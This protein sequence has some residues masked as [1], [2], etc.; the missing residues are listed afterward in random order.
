M[1]GRHQL[2]I[3][4]QPLA[5]RACGFGERDRRVIDPPP[6]LQ[7]LLTDFDPNST[8]DATEL[9]NIFTVHASLL[10]ATENDKDKTSTSFND[11]TLMHEPYRKQSRRLMGTLVASPFICPDPEPEKNPTFHL[12]AHAG[13]ATTTPQLSSISQLVAAQT[14]A[15]T[16]SFTPSPTIITTTDPSIPQSPSTFFLFPDLSCRTPG[17]YRLFFRLV[18]IT[19]DLTSTPGVSTPF[20]AE[21]TSDIFEVFAAKDFP[22]MRTS[23]K[24]TAGLK[25]AG[26]GI[27][28]KKG[29]S[30][31]GG[32]ED[33][34]DEKADGEERGA[35]EDKGQR[36]KRRPAK[37]WL[38]ETDGFVYG[39]T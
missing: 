31:K 36:Q 29:A 6:I 20:I 4:Q 17:H 38:Y 15:P 30:G 2:V 5:A 23:T 26:A 1:H 37:R 39:R 34:S 11:V 7:L 8:S 28:L 10:S 21:S 33:D 14:S 18:R 35:A 13:P 22:G 19:T 16:M 12:S 27:G 3:R 9:R 25:K 32:K 24:L